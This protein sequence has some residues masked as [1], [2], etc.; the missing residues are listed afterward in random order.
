MLRSIV[1]L[2]LLVP[3]CMA[4]SHTQDVAKTAEPPWCMNTKTKILHMKDLQ[5]QYGD[6]DAVT[7]DLTGV[8]TYEGN[9]QWERDSPCFKD[10]LHLAC[11][12]YPAKPKFDRYTGKDV[13]ILV[14]NDGSYWPVEIQV[15]R[16]S[17]D[18]LVVFA[19]LKGRVSC[20][21]YSPGST[22]DST[23]IWLFAAENTNA[24]DFNKT[25]AEL[26]AGTEQIIF[27]AEGD[28]FDKAQTLLALM[29]PAPTLAHVIQ[30]TENRPHALYDTLFY[31]LASFSANPVKKVIFV[32]QPGTVPN[33]KMLLR[34]AALLKQ[35]M[36]IVKEWFN[37]P[38][39]LGDY[40]SKKMCQKHRVNSWRLYR[41]L[42][43]ERC[44]TDLKQIVQD[45]FSNFEK[46][47][48]RVQ[49][50]SSWFA[51][52]D[53]HALNS[54]SY[55][56]MIQDIGCDPEYPPRSQDEKDGSM[57]CFV[58][59]LKY[60]NSMICAG[61]FFFVAIVVA[62]LAFV[63]KKFPHLLDRAIVEN[64]ATVATAE[65]ERSLRE[66]RERVVNNRRY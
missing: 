39:T 40:E 36:E 31:F 14:N 19:E 18:S 56:Q 63:C 10:Y 54:T 5:L 48:L 8:V 37:D 26:S 25:I 11:E 28:H 23:G 59:Q 22:Q 13:C 62:I 3:F 1:Q 46:M 15:H 49:N 4:A 50:A 9:N 64:E 66:A 27:V 30:Y 34:V 41:Q 53:H 6:C 42:T 55:N 60:Y 44:P 21:E 52:C 20:T 7:D 29:Q 12:K 43:W 35:G 61:T 51:G 57:D 65:M 17:S 24:I 45:L 38:C 16:N 33:P 58:R 47:N 32:L 2:V